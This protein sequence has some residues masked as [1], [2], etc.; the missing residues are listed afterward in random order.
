MSIAFDAKQTVLGLSP[1]KRESTVFAFLDICGCSWGDFEYENGQSPEKY[2]Y[3][4]EQ[5]NKED[6]E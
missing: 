4:D 2:I 1:E 5:L 6:Y 3:G